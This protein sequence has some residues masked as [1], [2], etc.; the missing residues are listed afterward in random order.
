MFWKPKIKFNVVMYLDPDYL[1]KHN[2]DEQAYI[3]PTLQKALYKTQFS[4]NV[5]MEINITAHDNYLNGRGI[6]SDICIEESAT[7]IRSMY[8]PDYNIV[9]L[10]LVP[11]S[12][13]QKYLDGNFG[14]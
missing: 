4:P 1:K 7:V 11:C 9:Q 6:K 10:D 5:G 14:T 8:T 3:M 13:Y 12:G 2:L